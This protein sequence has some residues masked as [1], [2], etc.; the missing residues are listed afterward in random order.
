M[1]EWGDDL[2]SPHEYRHGGPGMAWFVVLV[3]FILGWLVA[4]GVFMHFSLWLIGVYVGTCI[5]CIYLLLESSY[6]KN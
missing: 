5:V 2:P 4:Q 3:S 1:T 6:G